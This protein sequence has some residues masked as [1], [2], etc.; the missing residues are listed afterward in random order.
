MVEVL[1]KDL[2]DLVDQG[3]EHLVVVVEQEYIL[4]E[5]ETLLP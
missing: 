1:L 5:Q 3:E 2:V 4:E